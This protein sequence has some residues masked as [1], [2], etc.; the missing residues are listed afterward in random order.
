M[1]QS[2][3][4]RKHSSQ[5]PTSHFLILILTTKSAYS[6]LVFFLAYLTH[7]RLT[8]MAEYH[9]RLRRWSE[10]VCEQLFLLWNVCKGKFRAPTH[11]TG[12]QLVHSKMLERFAH[13]NLVGEIPCFLRVP[14]IQPSHRNLSFSRSHFAPL[15]YNQRII[16]VRIKCIHVRFYKIQGIFYYLNWYDVLPEF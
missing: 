8:L 14:F 4:V 10:W 3:K 13:V 7:P 6:N 9:N 5:S 16:F 11:Q 1:F 2:K 12:S 15:K